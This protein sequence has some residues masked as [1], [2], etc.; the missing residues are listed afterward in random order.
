MSRDHD[1][2]Q[3]RHDFGMLRGDI[4]CSPMFKARRRA[5]QLRC[6]KLFLPVTTHIPLTQIIGENEK[7]LGLAG[8]TSLA[9]SLDA[10]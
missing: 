2:F 3:L 6:L 8:T 10:E 5:V 7:T 1:G 9:F 4:V